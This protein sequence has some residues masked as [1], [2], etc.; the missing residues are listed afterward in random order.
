MF[1]CHENI[2]YLFCLAFLKTGE[3]VTTQ[4]S[5]LIQGQFDFL[6]SIFFIMDMRKSTLFLLTISLASGLLL[7]GCSPKSQYESNIQQGGETLTK[8]RARGV[9]KIG[10]ALFVP[11][12]FEDSAGNLKGFEIDL[13][14]KLAE[15]LQVKTQFTISNFDELIPKLQSGEIDI[16][17]SG[18]SI[19]PDRALKVNFSIPYNESGIYIVGNKNSLKHLKKIEDLNN[20]KYVIGVVSGTVSEPVTRKLFPNAQIILY[21]KDDES[22]QA[23]KLMQLDAV[24]SSSPGPELEVIRNPKNFGLVGTNSLSNTGEAFAIQKGDADF[25]NFLNSWV[26]YHAADNWLS[27]KRQY[28]FRSLDWQ[29]PPEVPNPEK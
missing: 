6:G 17:I 26:L 5:Q 8:I 22:F 16:I 19:T 12:V 13:A 24:I 21:E 11:W 7:C 14:K 20:K 9:L 15:D 1:F 27:E 2:I 23:L 25:L 10:V 29:T 28:W 4:K 3:E 18:M